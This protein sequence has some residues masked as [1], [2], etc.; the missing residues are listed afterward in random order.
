MSFIHT[1]LLSLRLS[2]LLN[3]K[4]LF[5]RLQM[6]LIISTS[7]TTLSGCGYQWGATLPSST[8]FTQLPPCRGF[9]VWRVIPSPL[10]IEP[11]ERLHRA[12]CLAYR[13]AGG[14]E[15]SLS[16]LSA[17]LS[18]RMRPL[19]V[20]ISSYH[21][22]LSVH[23]S[24][25]AHLTPHLTSHLTSHM[26]SP[27]KEHVHISHPPQGSPPSQL[28]SKLVERLM[29]RLGQQLAAKLSSDVD[30]RDE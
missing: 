28:N 30:Q 13:E 10:V 16:P 5:K 4:A 14:Q 12:L 25:Q 20:Q 23:E 22:V 15:G 18:F 17:S 8:S 1:P 29:S 9:N 7:L 11:P 3:L 27:L 24:A 26:S 2:S 6:N 19:S 21:A